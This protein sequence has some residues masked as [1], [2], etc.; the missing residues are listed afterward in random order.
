MK[1]EPGIA[2]VRLEWDELESY[3][4]PLNERQRGKGCFCM[5]EALG[6]QNEDGGVTVRTKVG[7]TD[8][9]GLVEAPECAGLV[10]Q[11]RGEGRRGEAGSFDFECEDLHGI[12]S[13]AMACQDE[14]N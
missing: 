2:R 7:F 5:Q 13:A 3:E 14:P 6:L 11:V 8:D 12:D 10:L 9:A 1:E 4:A